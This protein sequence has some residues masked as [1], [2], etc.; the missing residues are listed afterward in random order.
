[1][2]DDTSL[3]VTT[4]R[5]EGHTIL[6]WVAHHRLC[7]FDRIQIY[8]NDSTD[9]TVKTLHTLAGLGVIEYHENRHKKGGHQMR[10]YRR[11]SRSEAYAECDWCMV[12]DADD[13]LNVRLGGGKVADLIAA[14]PDK[15][16]AILVNQRSFG[17]SGHQYLDRSLVTERF[18]RA[19]PAGDIVTTRMSPLKPLFKTR[20]FSRPGAHLPRDPAIEAPVHCNGSGLVDGEF[21]RKGGRS[22]DPEGRAFAQVHHYGLRDLASFLVHHVEDGEP[23]HRDEGLEIWR[24]LDRNDEEDHTLVS[25]APALWE[26]MQRLDEMSDG[27]LLRLRQKA[28][29]QWRV[30]A[31][32]LAER[33]DITALRDAILGKVPELVLKPESMVTPFRLPQPL[34]VFSSVRNASE[35]A[36]PDK[37]HKVAAS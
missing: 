15:A 1:M 37:P 26:E 22:F 16:D 9:T 12:L 14:C 2:T 34:P 5:N 20:A 8:Q 28:I 6:E 21:R 11:A 35:D 13:F 7:G 25:R 29:R 30:A 17:S 23:A 4:V 19:E 32:N 24:E 3:L 33:K 27:L 18:G 10:A 31:K 36:A